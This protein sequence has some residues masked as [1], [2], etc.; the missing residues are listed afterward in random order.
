MEIRATGVAT[1]VAIAHPRAVATAVATALPPAVA[2]AL[3]PA[4]ATALQPALAMHLRG[5]VT[6]ARVTGRQAVIP[7]RPEEMLEAT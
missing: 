3:P 4:V 5:V 1:A 2:T 6:T 7:S